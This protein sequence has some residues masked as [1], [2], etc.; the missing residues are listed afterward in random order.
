MYSQF[1]SALLLA[2]KLRAL[3]RYFRYAPDDY[4]DRRRFSVAT[5]AVTLAR[6]KRCKLA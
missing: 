2:R 6:Q 4:D 3:K 1:H 5:D